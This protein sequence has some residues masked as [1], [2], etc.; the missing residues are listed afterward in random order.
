M[1]FV[2]PEQ[3]QII[4]SIS[5]NQQAHFLRVHRSIPTQ[6]GWNPQYVFVEKIASADCLERAEVNVGSCKKVGS[7]SGSIVQNRSHPAAF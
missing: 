5:G 3:N 2:N 1:Y 6:R 7:Q 4:K